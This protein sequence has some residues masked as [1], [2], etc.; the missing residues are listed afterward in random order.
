MTIRFTLNGEKLE[1]QTDAESRLVDILRKSFGLL[2]TKTGCCIGN[3]GQCSVIF[4]GDV[5]K[6]CLIPAFKI[7]GSEIGT[8]EGFS[9]SDEYQDIVLGFAETEIE[10]CG[11]CNTG[12]IL[13]VEALLRS[14]KR[15]S[16]DEILPAFNG[17]ACRC[18][19]PEELVLGI[20]AAAEHRRRR[21][22]GR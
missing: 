3:C 11:L 22:H 13:T 2:G 4:N 17:I 19:E 8:I 10:N 7:S 1:V 21:I 20:Q 16:K 12:K 18:T 6:S 15:P 5:V 9:Q 14:N